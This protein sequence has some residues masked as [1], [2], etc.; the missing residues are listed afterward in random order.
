[1]PNIDAMNA[2]F[3]PRIGIVIAAASSMTTA[4]AAPVTYR[5]DPTHT[6]PSFEADHMGI[7]VWRG[8]MNKTEGELMLDK[9]AG[10]GWVDVKIDMGSMDF[11]QST[12][13]A[14]AR[15]KN[16]FDIETHPYAFYKGRLE[17]PR[18]GMPTKVIGELSINGRSKPVELE[19]QFIKCIPHP[20]FKREVCGADAS[21]KF[22]REEFGLD[23]GKQFGFRM[24]VLLRIQ[25]EAIAKE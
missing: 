11:G 10:N 5:V 20:L 4:L 17:S 7:S 21:G 24:D 1:L 15:G 19:I 9:A 2:C 14:W 8:K 23:Y 12:L 6:Y 3:L 25:V 22:N 16:F 13:N 18:D